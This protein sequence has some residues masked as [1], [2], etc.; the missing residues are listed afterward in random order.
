M[1]ASSLWWWTPVLAEDVGQFTRVVNQV[2]QL[3]QGKESYLPAKVPNG[4]ANQDH[5]RTKER[6]MAVV[7]FVD[8][9]TMTVSPKSK[10]TIEDY[11]YDADKGRAKGT[12]KVMEG[13]VEAV[14]PTAT[15]KIQQKDFQI[16][17]TTATAGIRG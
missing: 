13:V 4:V 17:T 12:I 8:E 9:S 2:E 6:S 3:K 10:I 15:E 5:V 16:H 11:M 14:I 1:L 7:Q